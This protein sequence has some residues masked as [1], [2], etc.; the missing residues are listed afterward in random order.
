VTIEQPAPSRLHWSAVVVWVLVAIGAATAGILAPVGSAIALL[1]VVMALGILVAICL[2]LAIV[3]KE[4][5]V[6]R[7]VQTVCGAVLVL[8]LA[9]AVLAIVAHASP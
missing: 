7:M 5:L 8:A 3:R 4:G 9:T 2:Q 1:P 6:T